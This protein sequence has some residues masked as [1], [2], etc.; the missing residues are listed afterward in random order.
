MSPDVTSH[1]KT[2]RSPPHEAKRVLSCVLQDDEGEVSGSVQL[3]TSPHRYA[4]PLNELKHRKE[5]EGTHQAS[6]RTS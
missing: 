1:T 6:P 5:S 3:R 2:L 4:R